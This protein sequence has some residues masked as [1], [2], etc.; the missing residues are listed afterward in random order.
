MLKVIKKYWIFMVLA[1]IFMVGEVV[2]DLFQPALM[3]TIVNDGVLGLNNGG[4]GDLSLVISTGLRMIV[5]VAIGGCFGILSGIFSNIGSLNFSNDIRKM[6]FK[7]VMSF[8]FEQTD[9]FTTGSLIT[10]LTNDINQVQQLVMLSTRGLVRT[11][12]IIIGGTYCML[13]LDL[14]F[15]VVV[16]IALPFIL[17]CI[18]YFMIKANPRFMVLQKK[19]DNVNSIMQEN[20]L[21]SRVV[22]AYVKEDYELNRFKNA[23]D[24]LVQ[25]QIDVLLMLSY[26]TPIM[27]IIL[28]IAV[29]A[30]I[31]IGGINVANAKATPGDVMAAITYTTQVL[32]ALTRMTNIF[33]TFSRGMI[34]QKRI[35][36]VLNTTPSI[37][38][39]TGCVNNND[40]QVKGR[41]GKI[42]FRKV[43]F[44]Y[45]GT[46]DYVIKDIS[47]V[48]NPGETVG[49]LGATGSG[50]TT[51]MQLIPRFYE[52]TEG[53]ILIDDVDVKEYKLKELREKVSFAFQKAEIFARSIKDNIAWGCTKATEEEIR[54]A[55]NVA[56][57]MEFIEKKPQGFDTI[58]NQGGTS[59]S[60]GQKQRLALARAILKKSDII[61][62]DDTTSALDN[63]TERAF[64]DALGQSHQDATKIIVAQ[65]IVSVKNSDR[66]VVIDNGCLAD[67]GTHEELMQS[68][69]IYQDIYAS[70]LKGGV[71]EHE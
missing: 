30:V 23:N 27:N 25:T 3:K 13:H 41:R 10:R 39:G 42:E 2:M 29:V 54:N 36:E 12:M 40:T 7:K 51:L 16:L 11:S 17:T 65:R 18:A 68:S 46:D 1:P 61:I 15:G 14:S 32:N 37:V 60:G 9:D 24:D 21:G 67:V 50:K 62:F 53:Q 28:N 59:L 22:K 47:L 34:S 8:S 58:Q 33:Q 66:I 48:I 49:V 38:D 44:A 71:S 45:P 35:S 6:A 56:Q 69:A 20:I 31:K 19:L 63:K 43:S 55:A 57:A 52:V 26:M 70:Q 64:Y 5:Y 4:V